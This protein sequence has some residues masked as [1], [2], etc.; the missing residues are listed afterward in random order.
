MAETDTHARC[1]INARL[2]LEGYFANDPM[3]YVGGNL[4]L[5]YEEGNPYEFGSAGSLRRPRRSEEA[6][7]NVPA[8]GREEGARRGHGVHV[9]EHAL[10]GS[11]YQARSLFSA[12]RR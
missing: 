9:A 8:V 11:D 3:V 5:Y 7:T 10:G 6:S 1:I 12:A 2:A 4:L